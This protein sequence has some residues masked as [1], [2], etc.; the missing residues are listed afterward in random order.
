M[1]NGFSSIYYI[2]NKI[3][4]S[5]YIP[6]GIGKNFNLPRHIVFRREKEKMC[7]SLNNL[8]CIPKFYV[9]YLLKKQILFNHK[10]RMKIYLNGLNIIKN[11]Y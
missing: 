11:N 9:L 10:N 3:P 8:F 2:Y 1:L 5:T 4:V 6:V 7:N